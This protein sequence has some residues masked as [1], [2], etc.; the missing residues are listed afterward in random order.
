MGLVH[1]KERIYFWLCLIITII[2]WVAILLGVVYDPQSGLLALNI[3]IGLAFVGF[4]AH[5]IMIGMIRANA[6]RV[7]P[8]Q[9]GQIDQLCVSI[10]KKLGMKKIPTVYILQSGGI[11]NAFATHFLRKNFVVLYSEVVELAYESGEAALSFI[12]CHEFTHIKRRHVVWHSLLSPAYIFPFL[13]LAYS[14]AS[15][16]TC[17]RYAAYHIPEGALDGILLLA[18]GKRLYKEVNK[19]ELVKQSVQERGFWVTYAEMAA[20][21]PHLVRRLAA[22]HRMK[23]QQQVPPIMGA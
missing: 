17:D 7:S 3:T 9:F 16:Y 12:I 10:A 14:R 1:P 19:D 4:F 18:A 21:H 6:I 5:G 15:E 20:T 22:A 13:Q 11:L 2:F 23:S 8:T